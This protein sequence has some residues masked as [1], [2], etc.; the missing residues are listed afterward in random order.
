MGEG[1]DYRQLAQVASSQMSEIIEVQANGQ[2]IIY[3]LGHR[4]P[5]ALIVFENDQVWSHE[6][7]ADGGDEINI[8]ERG[9]NYGW[10]VI[11]KGRDY[12]G[13]RITPFTQYEGMQQSDF[14]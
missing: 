1:F 12:L 3:S 11:T 2:P 14:D 6:H 10:L 7:G 5:P 8:I 4:N 9:Y 13:G